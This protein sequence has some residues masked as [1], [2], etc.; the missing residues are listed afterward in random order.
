M[1]SISRKTTMRT[2]ER[3]ARPLSYVQAVMA[4]LAGVRRWNQYNRYS[5]NCRFVARKHSKTV[6]RPIVGSS[7][8][9]F[10][11]WLLVETVSD[12]GQILKRDCRANLLGLLNQFFRDVVIDPLLEPL[13]SA[14]KPPQQSARTA[15]AFALNIGSNLGIAVT[16]CLQ[17]PT[18]PGLTCAGCS[19]I[20]PAQI[21]TNHLRS[22]TR[23]LG[24][25]VYRNLDVVIPIAAFDQGSSSRCLPFQ[26]SKL[27]IANRQG[28]PNPLV[29]QCD[30]NVLIRFPVSKHSG[31]E[32]DRG[33]SEFVNLLCR[34]HVAD[35]ATDSL[36]RMVCFQP[37]HCPH[38][39]IGQM[40]ESGNVA[41]IFPLR[42]FQNLIASVSKRLKGCIN[43]WTQ[44]YRD[45]K[46]AGDRY[47]LSHRTIVL[48]PCLHRQR[49]C[50]DFRDIEPRSIDAPV[51]P[52][53][54]W[55]AVSRR[56]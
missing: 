41:A 4:S 46:L 7:A 25:K 21:H 52:R 44:L 45:L 24:R 34:F 10:V 16:G 36:T 56:S 27:I 26:Q 43:F 39:P 37:C 14:R 2:L 29:H 15:S 6:E 50:V 28:Q 12:I 30:T 32:A 42:N 8:L 35:N 51:P 1:V 17:L 40:M 11:S 3:L 53:P 5:C 22:L 31:V 33:R 47:G 55:D 19:N 9:S 18:I 48:H 23:W 38:L 54:Q 20:P 13:F 49:L